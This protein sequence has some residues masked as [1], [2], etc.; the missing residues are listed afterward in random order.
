MNKSEMVDAISAKTGL[1]KKD[2]KLALDAFVESVMD[3]VASG[4]EVG[5]TGFRQVAGRSSRTE[6]RKK[7]FNRRKN[8]NPGAQCGEVQGR[9]NL[10]GGSQ[11]RKAEAQSETSGKGKERSQTEAQTCASARSTRLTAFQTSN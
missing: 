6:T 2:A 5:F 10:E 11:P 1:T 7:S 9:R 4:E 8:P 3:C